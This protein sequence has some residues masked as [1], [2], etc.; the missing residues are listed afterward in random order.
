MN[1]A[2]GTARRLLLGLI[3]ASLWFGP[4]A[5][6]AQHAP[7]DERQAFANSPAESV[8]QP[9]PTVESDVGRWNIPLIRPGETGA[10]QTP[11]WSP[12]APLRRIAAVEAA[13]GAQPLDVQ[14]INGEVAATP[15]VQPLQVTARI[16]EA[17]QDGTGEGYR[18][19]GDC[20]VRQG[21]AVVRSREMVLWRTRPRAPDAAKWDVQL[22][23]EGDVTLTDGTR[24]EHRQ[25][26]LLDL[27]SVSFEVESEYSATLSAAPDDALYERAIERRRQ[28][29]GG[30]RVPIEQIS[31]QTAQAGPALAVPV[32]PSPFDLPY[33]TDPFA[34]RLASS[35]APRHVTLYPRVLGQG[36]SLQT[37]IDPNSVPAEYVTTITGGVRLVVDEFPMD[38]GGQMVLTT[39]DLS[40]DRAIIW[41]DAD[42]IDDLSSGFDLDGQTPFEVYLEGN[43]EV[44]QGA[45]V[46]RAERAFYDLSE[47]R[48]LLVNSEL[49]T[50]IPQFDATVRMRAREIRQHSKDRFT[51]RDAWFSTSEMGVPG[52]RIQ[53]SQATIDRRMVPGS[54]T[55]NPETGKV[56][57]GVLWFTGS[58]NKLYVEN[59]PVG[60]FPYVSS[61]AES[62]DVP[63]RNLS[64]GFDSIFG[65]DANSLGRRATLRARQSRLRL[66]TGGRLLREPRPRARQRHQSH[67][68]VHDLWPAVDLDDERRPV[69]RL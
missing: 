58:G 35:T 44:R 12:L 23:C 28:S 11:G 4:H 53:S 22:Y 30:S 36:F 20:E 37:Q 38:L 66:G 24:T 42:R 14:A 17:W 49:R 55:V 52:Y 33:S 8:P 47:E 16:A 46:L 2:L 15:P 64:F 27:S 56:E 62:P 51:A 50:L 7:V 29:P 18:L 6:R 59:V 60:Y 40:A 21:P 32:T 69:L 31:M 5:V 19:R 65:F 9:V 13:D 41:T 34:S 54:A 1:E 39:I 25:A 63:L 68:S 57:G 26:M 3:V 10:A 45:N 61:P 48:G 67:H 43:I